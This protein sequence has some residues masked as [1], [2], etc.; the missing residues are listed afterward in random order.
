MSGMARR[1]QKR[2][3]AQAMGSSSSLPSCS[4]CDASSSCGKQ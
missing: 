3:T 1:F 2:D 4:A